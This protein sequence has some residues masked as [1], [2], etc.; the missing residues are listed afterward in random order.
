MALARG[1]LRVVTSTITLVEVL[2][3]PLRQGAGEP[4]RQYRDMLPA[5]EGLTVQP[6]SAAI[7]EDPPTFSQSDFRTGTDVVGQ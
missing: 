1:E 5:A 4:A 7:A 3:Q 2:T 6:V